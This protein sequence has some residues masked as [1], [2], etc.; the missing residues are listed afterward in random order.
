MRPS[1]NE[2]E[3]SY[4]FSYSLLVVLL[5][6]NARDSNDLSKTTV[7]YFLRHSS[8]FHIFYIGVTH[9]SGMFWLNCCCMCCLLHSVFRHSV[10]NQFILN[11]QQYKTKTGKY[12]CKSKTKRWSFELKQNKCKY[13]KCRKKSTLEPQVSRNFR[14]KTVYCYQPKRKTDIRYFE[15]THIFNS[16]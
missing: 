3:Q 13:F 12:S 11:V 14:Y 8:F 1:Y 7:F 2:V 5:H 9:C 6:E 16:S 10:N 15:R 4:F